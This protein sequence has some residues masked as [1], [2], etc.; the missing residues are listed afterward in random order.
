[1]SEKIKI[2]NQF[3]KQ[4]PLEEMNAVQ[5]AY[6]T[7]QIFPAVDLEKELHEVAAARIDPERQDRID[8]ERLE[9]AALDSG[10]AVVKFMRREYDIV[11]RNALCE[12]AL[13]M[14]DDVGAAP[15]S[16]QCSD[17]FY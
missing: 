15:V 7:M 5:I 16:D 8:A 9:I 1:M 12:K 17:G 4:N 13:E 3:W 2:P 10:A 11:N 14:Q 6:F